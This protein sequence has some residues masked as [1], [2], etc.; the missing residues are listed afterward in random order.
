[1]KL[2]QE[3]LGTCSASV[4]YTSQHHHAHLPSQHYYYR[5]IVVII[6]ITEVSLTVRAT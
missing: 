5:L 6:I 4:G 3:G 2:E 1:M